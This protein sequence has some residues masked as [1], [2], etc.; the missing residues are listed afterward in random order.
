MYKVSQKDSEFYGV[1]G[2]GTLEKHIKGA[3][4]SGYR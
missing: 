2:V 3:R 4:K 1:F